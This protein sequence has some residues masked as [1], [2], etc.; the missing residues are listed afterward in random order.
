MCDV[1]IVNAVFIS[2]FLVCIFFGGL[3]CVGHTYVAYILF[4]SI[5]GLLLVNKL[6]HS[7]VCII[8]SFT[9][10]TVQKF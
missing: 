3:E 6:M 9:N 7:A 4:R 8:V 2:N 10:E 5:E 1:I